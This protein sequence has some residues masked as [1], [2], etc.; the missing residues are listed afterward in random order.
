MKLSRLKTSWKPKY[1]PLFL[2]VNEKAGRGKESINST[3]ML[4]KG[5][6]T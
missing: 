5:T 2:N 1:S 3:I 4:V 6:L